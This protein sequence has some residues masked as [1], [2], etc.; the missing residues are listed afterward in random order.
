F[1]Q[2]GEGILQEVARAD[3]ICYGTLAQRSPVARASVQAL[4][5]AAP[6]AA[7][8][9]FDVNLRQHYWSPAVIVES[10]ELADVL[11]LNDEELPIVAKS[12]GLAGDEP[13]Q[14]RLLAKRFELKAVALTKGANGSSLLVGGE[15]VSR[16][17]SKLIVADTVGAGDSYTAALTLGLLAGHEPHQIVEAAHRVADYVCTQPGAMPPIPPQLCVPVK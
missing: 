10:L 4:H 2:P 17:G 11:K 8:R 7:L 13:S 9:I 14:M 15:L 1:L 3:A 5:R 16:P 12:L 6:A